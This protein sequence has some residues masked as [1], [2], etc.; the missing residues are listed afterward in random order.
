MYIAWCLCF[1]PQVKK[2]MHLSE[3][4]LFRTY[5]HFQPFGIKAG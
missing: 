4:G 3:T 5:L 1:E 2:L